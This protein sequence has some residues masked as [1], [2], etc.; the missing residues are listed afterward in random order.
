MIERKKDNPGPEKPE[1][2]RNKRNHAVREHVRRRKTATPGTRDGA[3][4]SAKN[5]P[6]EH[7]DYGPLM[8]A[9]GTT[10]RD[11]V[12]GLLE[13]LLTASVR[14]VDKFD[15]QELPFGLAVI[16]GVNPNDQMEAMLAAQA[17]ATHRLALTYAGRLNRAETIEEQDSA[18]RAFNKLARTFTTQMETLKRYRSGPEQKMTVQHVSVNDGSQAIVGNVTQATHRNAPA[19]FASATPALTD[20][21]QIPMQILSEAQRV[22]VRLRSKPKA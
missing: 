21:R 19:E 11:F 16:K 7:D 3:E 14:G 18:E 2:D 10:D 12:D 1:R 8:K 4:P 17:A 20:A 15:G 6:T 13:Q 9:L 22:P 5:H